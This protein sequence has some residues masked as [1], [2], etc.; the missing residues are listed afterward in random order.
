MLRILLR[1]LSITLIVVVLVHGP[2]LSD[3]IGRSLIHPATEVTE[4]TSPTGQLQTIR[5]AMELGAARLCPPAWLSSHITINDR[6][7]AFVPVKRKG[8]IVAFAEIPMELLD[9]LVQRRLRGALPP[10]DPIMRMRLRALPAYDAE[11]AKDIAQQVLWCPTI[12]G[13]TEDSQLSPDGI[14]V[15]ELADLKIGQHTWL[16]REWVDLLRAMALLWGILWLALFGLYLLRGNRHLT[17]IPPQQTERRTGIRSV[18]WRGLAIGSIIA[19][20]LFMMMDIHSVWPRAWAKDF[21]KIL[22]TSQYGFVRHAGMVRLEGALLCTNSADASS[23]RDEPET[24]LLVPVAV[25]PSHP[26]LS[27]VSFQNPSTVAFLTWTIRR[28]LRHQEL[29]FRLPFRM[30]TFGY[31]EQNNEDES[32][33]SSQCQKLSKEAQKVPIS[34]VREPILQASSHRPSH[35]RMKLIGIGLL[36]LMLGLGLGFLWMERFPNGIRIVSVRAMPPGGPK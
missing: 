8:K 33:L 14:L 34:Q 29:G 28:S 22:N 36:S 1:S 11:T 12:H 25:S 13:I 2:Q 18:L 32:S 35:Y 23:D 9:Q 30:S 7:L 10:R 3:L 26:I 5:G 16:G 15:G 21:S 4:T 17:P 27:Y 20:G 19:L 31:L 24:K 6:A